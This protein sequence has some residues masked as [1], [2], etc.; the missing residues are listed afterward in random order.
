MRVPAVILLVALALTSAC[1]MDSRQQVLATDKSAVE[2]RAMST[3][4]FD[5]GDKN[6]TVRN[7]IAT[8]QDLGFVVDKADE[9]LGT[10]S[11]TKFDGSVMRMTITV[12]PRG[13][14]QMVVRAS[15]QYRMDAISDP[16]PYQ[17][18]FEAL[19]KA[20]FLTAHEID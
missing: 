20:M 17:Q 14:D 1:Q 10:I 16:R 4:A 7:V 8:L 12:R 18:F 5:T 3:R 13:K 11:G 6:L 15:G 19:S 2:L 9:T